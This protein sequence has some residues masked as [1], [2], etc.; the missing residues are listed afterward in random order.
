MLLM[1]LLTGQAK[2]SSLEIF[3]ADSL[4]G[5]MEELKLAFE[6]KQQ[7]VTINLTSGRSQELAER[8]L[9]GETCDVF[10]PSSP[11]VI[12]QDLM[13][14]KIASSGKI[15]A[16]WSVIFSTNE[17]VIITVKGNPLG[18]RRVTDLARPGVKFVRVTGEK[19]LATNRTIDFLKKAAAFEGM[20]DLAQ[21]IVEGTV[22]DPARSNT[23]P[24]TIR[25]IQA[26]KA[27]AGVVYY[28]AAVAARYDLDIVRFAASV[29]Q[30]DGIRNAATVPETAQNKKAA[31]DFVKL[32]LS[33]EGRK[34]LDETG[35]PAVV[36]AIRNGD[37]PAELK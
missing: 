31:I 16:S 19:D 13:N 33:T 10:A 4:A 6:R 20:P 28:S 34:V 22:V 5:P 27:D 17:M 32:L 36:P 26:G 18:I 1:A 24:E 23:V 7:G 2:A 8:I 35:Q 11:A 12:E 25:A 29:N 30:S 37:V 15:A 14:K 21:K 3:H 9:K